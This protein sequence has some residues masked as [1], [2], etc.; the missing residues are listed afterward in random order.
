MQP[1]SPDTAHS[2]ETARLKLAGAAAR[3]AQDVAAQR[4]LN[5]AKRTQLVLAI[6]YLYDAMVLFG[7]CAAGYVG[8]AVPMSVLVLLGG[9]IAAVHFAYASGW[10]LKQSDPT[11]FLPQQLY[12]IAIA[13]GVAI[14]APQI[15]FQPLA[16]LFAISAFSFMAPNPRNLVVCWVA[17]AVAAVSVIFLIGPRL[18]MPTGTLAG[19]ALTSAVVIGLVARCV[20]IAVLFRKLRDRLSEKNDELHKAMERIEALANRDELTGLPNRRSISATLRE[21]AAL[22]RRLRLPL[23]VAYIDLDH[24]KRINDEYGHLAGDRALQL[25]AEQAQGAIRET[26]VL[27]RYG[28]EEF[29]LIM[30]GTPLHDANGPLERIRN[31]VAAFDWS[32]ID[33]E[34]HLTITIGATQY[35]PGEAVEDM[36]RRADMALYLGKEAGRDRVVLDPT[37]AERRTPPRPVVVRG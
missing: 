12:A 35:A 21:Q 37:P 34:V 29:L 5:S 11:L 7:F 16:T 10:S 8:L 26:D 24:F 20:W 23:S 17:A 9:V 15:G 30:L 31:R 18:A 1:V 27:G 4:L 19:E 28:G 14:A 25:F 22:C 3:E 32:A 13:L 6:A 2:P 33:P 36:M